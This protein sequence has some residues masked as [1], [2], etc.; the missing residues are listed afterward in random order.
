MRKY[1]AYILALV[2][3]S[4]C[5]N[6]K[7]EALS[8]SM[9]P[10]SPAVTMPEAPMESFEVDLEEGLRTD[11]QNPD[12]I[13]QLM[14]DL[15]GK[16]VADIGAGSGY[17]SFKIARTAAKVIALDVDPNALEYINSQK[18]I[19]G[20]WSDNI[21]ARLTPPDVPN[22]LPNEV[23]LALIVNTFNYIPG[24]TQYFN[25]LYDALKTGASIMIID[26]K[27]GDSPVGPSDKYKA[28]VKEIRTLLRKAGF[29]RVKEDEKSLQYQFILTAEKR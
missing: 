8:R 21:E 11:W 1:T 20:E 29:R 5:N 13:M 25:R 27:K 18:E 10:V 16:T 22:L 26:F 6:E 4:A 3:F 23:D 19:V 9:D 2:L 7:K 24:K 28:E 17:F 15:S 14:G 12:F